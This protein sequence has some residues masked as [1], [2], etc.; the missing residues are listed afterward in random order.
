MTI[1]RE[2]RILLFVLLLILF[3]LN[4]AVFYFFPTSALVLYYQA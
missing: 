3:A 1:H 2:G 4:W